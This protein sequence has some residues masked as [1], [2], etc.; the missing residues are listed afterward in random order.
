MPKNPKVP[1]CALV[2]RLEMNGKPQH[3]IPRLETCRS[4]CAS[5]NARPRWGAE[6]RAS[7]PKLVHTAHNWVDVGRPNQSYEK[8]SRIWLEHG[9]A[10]EHGDISN[11][12]M[13]PALALP[14]GIKTVTVNNSQSLYAGITF[15]VH[16]GLPELERNLT[17]GLE[18]SV[19]TL[20]SGREDWL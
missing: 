5:V 10:G 17:K 4:S 8:P 7:L 15:A 20:Y 19:L 2:N 18:V 9:R 1:C 16:R 12:G 11:D 3:Q 6:E 13:L 14:E